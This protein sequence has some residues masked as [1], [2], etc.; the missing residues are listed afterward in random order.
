MTIIAADPRHLGAK[1]AITSVLHSSAMK[2]HP[3]VHMIVPGGGIAINGAKW[4]AKRP[5]FPT[6][7]HAAVEAV[8]AAHA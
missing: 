3:H 8:P 5:N 7:R 1:I 4:T 6:A 2:H